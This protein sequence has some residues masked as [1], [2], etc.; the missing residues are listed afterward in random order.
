N[1]LRASI[2]KESALCLLDFDL[3]RGTRLEH[4]QLGIATK[5]RRVNGLFPIIVEPRFT[6]GD[7][8]LF[9]AYHPMHPDAWFPLRSDTTLVESASACLSAA[10]KHMSEDE[11]QALFSDRR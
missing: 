5:D 1:M 8:R 6:G 3:K 10:W 2:A 7:E 9:V 11:V 4:V